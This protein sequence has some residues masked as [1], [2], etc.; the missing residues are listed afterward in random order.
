MPAAWQVRNPATKVAKLAKV[1]KASD[2]QDAYMALTSHWDDPSSMVLGMYE[3]GPPSSATQGLSDAGVTEQMLWLDLVGYL[4]DDILV[5]WTGRRCRFPSR[6]GSRFSTGGCWIWPGGCRSQPNFAKV[7]QSGCYARCSIAMFP[8]HWWTGRRWA[9][10]CPS[11]RGCEETWPRGPST[12][13]TSVGCV[14]REYSIPSPSGGPG[15]SIGRAVG[16][17]ATSCGMYWS[18][19]RGWTGGCHPSAKSVGWS[20]RQL[21]LIPTATRA[22]LTIQ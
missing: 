1:L 6:P 20:K 16:T 3:H 19:K 12:S 10:A 11:D 4:P 2:P 8:L 7:G 21:L 18:S 13:S 22:I 5:K 9:L 17:W 15:I 14:T